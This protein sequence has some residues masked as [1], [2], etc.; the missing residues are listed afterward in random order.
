MIYVDPRRVL[1]ALQV[2]A[3]QALNAQITAAAATTGDGDGDGDGTGVCGIGEHETVSGVGLNGDGDGDWG[4]KEDPS[5]TPLAPAP[6]PVPPPITGTKIT[7]QGIFAAT[8]NPRS[9]NRINLLSP[10]TGLQATSTSTCMIPSSGSGSGLNPTDLSIDGVSTY[11]PCVSTTVSPEGVR[12]LSLV[13]VMESWRSKVQTHAVRLMNQRGKY[14]FFLLQNNL[15]SLLLLIC[16]VM[17][18]H[19]IC[20]DVMCCDVM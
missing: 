8:H 12:V 2:A 7:P 1:A 16:D 6:V 5:D 15:L 13:S 18:C 4:H 14:Y 3:T 11:V 19:A 9:A 17:S 10:H 20:C